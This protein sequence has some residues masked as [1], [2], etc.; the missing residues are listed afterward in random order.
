LLHEWPIRGISGAP[1]SRSLGIGGTRLPRF[2][3]SPG[4]LHGNLQIVV[5]ERAEFSRGQCDCVLSEVCEL[6]SITAKP[7]PLEKTVFAAG[8][9]ES[10]S[11]FD[12][13][14]VLILVSLRL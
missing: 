6:K 1:A 3:N 2:Q 12:R 9:F 10:Q 7:K 13:F 4:R 11:S 8:D 14:R 5:F